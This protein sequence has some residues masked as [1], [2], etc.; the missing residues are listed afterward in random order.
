MTERKRMTTAASVPVADTL[1]AGA[2]GS[3][4]VADNAR[5][6]RGLLSGR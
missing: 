2:R 3:G 4:P 1:T 5:G 6:S